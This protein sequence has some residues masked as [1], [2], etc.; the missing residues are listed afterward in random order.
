MVNKG[1]ARAGA[2]WL[3][4]LLVLRTKGGKEG[5]AVGPA[6]CVTQGAL[7][8][9]GRGGFEGPCFLNSLHRFTDLTMSVCTVGLLGVRLRLRKGTLRA[10]GC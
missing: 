4:R 10:L 2:R 9:R 7:E 1:L 3:S 8:P 6:A 5:I